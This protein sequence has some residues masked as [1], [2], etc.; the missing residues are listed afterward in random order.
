MTSSTQFPARTLKPY[1]EPVSA[2]E[3][4]E[5]TT[6]FSVAF[7]D[8][9]MLIPTFEAIVFLGVDL[10]QSEVPGGLYFQD[11]ASY[12][13]GIRLQSASDEDGARFLIQAPHQLGSFFGYENALDEL[14]A[15]SLRRRKALA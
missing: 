3:L 7:L 6:Y 2:G 1:A 5:G 15:C 10:A 11:A 9:D 8:D 4:Q 12:R 13:Q 14:L